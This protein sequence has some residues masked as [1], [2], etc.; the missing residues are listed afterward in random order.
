MLGGYQINPY[1]SVEIE[2]IIHGSDRSAFE[3]DIDTEEVYAEYDLSGSGSDTVFW[4]QPT[5]PLGDAWSL[6]GKVGW[7]FYD[8]EVTGWVFTDDDDGYRVGSEHD[9]GASFYKGVGLKWEGEAIDI[10][11][12]AVNQNR[13][14]TDMI[15]LGVTFRF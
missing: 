11:L 4:V 13:L 15:S 14:E 9:T 2:H 3:M 5:L 1:L 7:G 12:E 8:Y 6:Y 10:R